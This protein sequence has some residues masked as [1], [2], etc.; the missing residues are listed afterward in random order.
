MVFARSR[1][2]RVL[3]LRNPARSHQT[4]LNKNETRHRAR[5]LTNAR[6]LS[7]QPSLLGRGGIDSDA[8]AGCAVSLPEKEGWGRTAKKR[9]S[10]G[11]RI[12][13]S[14]PFGVGAVS[15]PSPRPSP[16]GRGRTRR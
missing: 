4:N 2:S 13:V 12:S 3:L 10:F 11:D 5:E 16:L 1:P 6:F 15:S 8:D 14:Q 9:K 7:P